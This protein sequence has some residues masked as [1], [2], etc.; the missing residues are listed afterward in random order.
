MDE[1]AKKE[2]QH[3]ES[4]RKQY[5][6]RLGPRYPEDVWDTRNTDYQAQAQRAEKGAEYYTSQKIDDHGKRRH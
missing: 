6:H 3:V 5:E 2:R 1:H 4:E